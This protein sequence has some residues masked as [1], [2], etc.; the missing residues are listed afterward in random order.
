MNTLFMIL[1]NVFNI[2][3]TLG[4]TDNGINEVPINY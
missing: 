3:R 2:I 4:R 1:I